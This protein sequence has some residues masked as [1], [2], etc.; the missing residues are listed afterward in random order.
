MN[1]QM[2]ELDNINIY[3]FVDEDGSKVFGYDIGDTD[4]VKALGL[5]EVFKRALI[6][7]YEY[8]EGDDE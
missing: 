2:I 8:V 3:Q 6:A 4:Y 7:D 5:V 1:E